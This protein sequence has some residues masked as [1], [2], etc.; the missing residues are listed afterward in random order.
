MRPDPVGNERETKAR[1]GDR[2]R[3]RRRGDVCGGRWM[4][5][6]ADQGFAIMRR[7][8]VPSAFVLVRK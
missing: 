4:S 3:Q 8:F 2:R 5:A 6:A 1:D 7:A